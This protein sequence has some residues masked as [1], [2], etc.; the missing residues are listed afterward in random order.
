MFEWALGLWPFKD[1]FY[2]NSTEFTLNKF[3]QDYC[4]SWGVPDK[5]GVCP[6]GRGEHLP[7]THALVAS[8]SGGGVAPGGV[9]GGADVGLITMTCRADGT[10]LK[11]TT[12]AMYVYQRLHDVTLLST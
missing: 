10:L 12:P 3:G 2:S 6:H 7:F 9:I 8:L 5:T 11:P 1:T 4:S